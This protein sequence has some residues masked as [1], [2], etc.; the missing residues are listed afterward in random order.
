MPERSGQRRQIPHSLKCFRR[1]YLYGETI[2]QVLKMYRGQLCRKTPPGGKKEVFLWPHSGTETALCCFRVWE[3]E[4]EYCLSPIRFART[5]NLGN[6]KFYIHEDLSNFFY[7]LWGCW[8]LFLKFG[9][10]WWQSILGHLQNDFF[11]FFDLPAL[12]R[13]FL[14]T[15]LGQVISA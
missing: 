5:L 9:L 4:T 11:F 7:W 8:D 1:T 10:N 13:I 12:K 14:Q 2:A 15:H 6:P 3:F